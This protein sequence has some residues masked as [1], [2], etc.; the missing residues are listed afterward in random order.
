MRRIRGIVTVAL[1][2]NATSTQLR[3]LGRL[4]GNI[5]QGRWDSLADTFE[6]MDREA[7]TWDPAVVTVLHRLAG[8][9]FRAAGE[10]AAEEVIAVPP[11]A[12]AGES[13]V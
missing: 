11:A 2:N 5:E 13:R 4:L 6:R 1:P 3:A 9:V 8:E 10:R 12:G 7:A